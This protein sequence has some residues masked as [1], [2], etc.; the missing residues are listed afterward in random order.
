MDCVRSPICATQ[1]V[2]KLRP[3]VVNNS[4]EMCLACKQHARL[5]R[6]RDGNRIRKTSRAAAHAATGSGEGSASSLILPRYRSALLFA[7]IS[8]YRTCSR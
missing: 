2:T 7:R 1:F 3:G 4:P 6:S 8:Y 5:N